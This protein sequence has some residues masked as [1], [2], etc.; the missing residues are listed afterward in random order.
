MV[1]P[2]HCSVAHD[3]GMYERYS[4]PSG[5]CIERAIRSALCISEACVVIT[6]LGA[7]VVPEV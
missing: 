7:P 3:S 1:T 5:A 4:P 6:P 2:T